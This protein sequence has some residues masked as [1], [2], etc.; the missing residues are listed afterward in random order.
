[1]KPSM[2]HLD[3][4]LAIDTS[5]AQTSI[6]LLSRGEILADA[7]LGQRNHAQW[8]LPAINTLLAEA[9]LGFSELDAI[10]YGRGPGS[11]TGLR[12]GC[13]IAKGLAYAY[14]L[15]LIPLSTLRII[16]QQAYEQCDQSNV[17]G[18]L[19]LINAHMNQLYWAYF[20]IS[21]LKNFED[22]LCLSEPTSQDLIEEYLSDP[23]QI[24]VPQEGS[25]I[26][27]GVDFESFIAQLPPSI[28]KNTIGSLPLF[29]SA[30]TMIKI[31]SKSNAPI[32]DAK[33]ASLVY[34]NNPFA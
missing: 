17:S 12:I 20:D 22:G 7:K 1:M 30:A 21:V 28:Q 10:V 4:L 31:A 26:L 29:P 6:A 19:S 5:S 11:F 34:L 13:S 18:I 32:V 9:S 8:I 2:C 14:D 23:G 16:A 25:L 15:P 3:H 24:S 33:T 27:T